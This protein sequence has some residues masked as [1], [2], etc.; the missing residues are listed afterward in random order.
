VQDR[1]TWLIALSGTFILTLSL[2]DLA[3]TKFILIGG[4]VAP[5]GVFLFSIIFVVR[6]MLH[7]IAGQDYVRRTILVAAVLNLFVAA[8]FYMIAQLPAPEFFALAEPW[9]AIFALA[10]AIVLASITAA[11]L[12]QLLNTYVYQRLWDAGRPQWARVV[13]SNL[14]SLPV[15]SVLFTALAFVILPPAF[16]ADPIAFSDAVVRVASGQT[17]IKLIIVL[18]MTPMV[19]LVPDQPELEPTLLR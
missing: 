13:G 6:D 17:L 1:T 9:D 19:Y 10:P 12:S 8:Y 18:A 2:A 5:G 7:K 11:V 14:A 16:G 15:D 3:A 4:V